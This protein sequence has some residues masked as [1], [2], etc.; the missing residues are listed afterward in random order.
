M[1]IEVLFINIM[2]TF[3]HN[4]NNIIVIYL[5]LCKFLTYLDKGSHLQ[6]RHAWMPK[7]PKIN[8][9]PPHTSTQSHRPSFSIHWLFHPKTNIIESCHEIDATKT[10]TSSIINTLKFDEWD[11]FILR[12]STTSTYV[13][14]LVLSHLPM[15][16]LTVITI[17]YKIQIRHT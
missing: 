15:K 2:E 12:T 17:P 8:W 9:I 16:I 13:G 6:V 3:S 4:K 7:T 1:S 11:I 5:S 10:N 14:V